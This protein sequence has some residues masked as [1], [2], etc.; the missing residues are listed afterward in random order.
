MRPGFLC[1]RQLE[2]G[3]QQHVHAIQ[4]HATPL[5]ESL[6]TSMSAAASLVKSMSVE[7]AKL[8]ALVQVRSS[9]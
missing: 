9:C 7:H 8:A 6:H 3:V 5:T 2:Q 4:Q 1:T